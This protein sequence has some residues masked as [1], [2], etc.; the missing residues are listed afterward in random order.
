MLPLVLG[1]ATA[2][3][4][5]QAEHGSALRPGHVYV[6]PPNRHLIVEP[7]RLRLFEGPR[8]NASR[9]AI[10]P[11][12]RSAAR[13]YGE[14]VVGVVLS[15]VLDDGAAGLA[16]IKSR[17]GVALVQ[18][19]K[20]ARFPGMP[21]S[22]MRQVEVDGVLPVRDIAARL[23]HLAGHGKPEVRR[24][25]QESMESPLM[26]DAPDLD[27]AVQNPTPSAPSGLTCPECGG[28]LWER[29]EGGVLRYRCHV[30]HALS[31]ESMLVEQGEA[32][33]GALWTAVR[34]LEERAALFRRVTKSS[35]ASGLPAR[36][37]EQADE[38]E[39]QAGLIREL[40]M[41]HMDQV[42]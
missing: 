11:L 3:P 40:L 10:D 18:D 35:T 26:S 5:R 27:Q 13:A 33:E 17:G 30:G 19:P 32:L 24:G 28:A 1:R 29:I 38:L 21:E 34:A 4:V 9:P 36:S 14:R 2:L 20:E 23:T 6:A 22:A 39:Q 42:A 8:E 37:A 25:G 7:G 31:I 15:G 12:F 41:R 16:I